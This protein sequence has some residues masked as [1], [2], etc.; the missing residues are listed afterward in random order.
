M[1]TNLLVKSFE[2]GVC[3]TLL[4][5][6][7]VFALKTVINEFRKPVDYKAQQERLA[8]LEAKRQ[9]WEDYFLERKM[10]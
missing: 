9:R 10:R 6:S 5:I 7:S 1:E 3:M 4:F 2:S 8:Y